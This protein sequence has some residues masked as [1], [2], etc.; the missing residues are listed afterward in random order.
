MSAV[1]D[2]FRAQFSFS[3]FPKNGFILND[4]DL[5]ELLPTYPQTLARPLQIRAILPQ[6]N[7]LLRSQEERKKKPKES[8][9]KVSNFCGLKGRRS[10]NNAGQFTNSNS[11]WPESE[12]R[13]FE[14]KSSPLLQFF[15]RLFRLITTMKIKRSGPRAP[16]KFSNPR[17]NRLQ[18]DEF[19][20]FDK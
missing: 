8:K 19:D 1:L 9:S 15:D 18:E 3:S 6:D 20:A 17:H 12:D 13:F 4:E 14:M 5:E 11:I 2:R 7:F 10:K 16:L